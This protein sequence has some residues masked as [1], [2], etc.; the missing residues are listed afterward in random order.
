MPLLEPAVDP[1]AMGPREAYCAV[2][3]NPCCDRAAIVAP[4][5]SIPAIEECSSATYL[6]WYESVCGPEPR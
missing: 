4:S 3:D 6:G 2:T 1:C 5:V